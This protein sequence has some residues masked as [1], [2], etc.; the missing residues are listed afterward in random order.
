MVVEVRHV[1]GQHRRKMAAVNDQDPVQ[2]FAAD[3]GDPSFGDRVRLRCPHLW[4]S[5][6][7]PA[8]LTRVIGVLGC[9]GMA[10][11]CVVASPFLIFLQLVH[12]LLLLGRSSAVGAE[13][14]VHGGDLVYSW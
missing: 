4:G 14:V 7:R 12:L 2:Q 10:M 8:P 6:R 9:R 11:S 1:L 13:L 3:S 5:K